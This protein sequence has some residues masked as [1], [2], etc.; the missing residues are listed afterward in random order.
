[1]LPIHV[2]PI[3]IWPI[4]PLPFEADPAIESWLRSIAATAHV[5]FPKEPGLVTGGLQILW[6]KSQARRH[7]IVVVDHP[8]S[9]SIEARQDR[10]SRWRAERCRHKGVSQPRSVFGQRVEI[11][12]FQKRMSR[13]AERVKPMIIR[14]N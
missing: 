7:G 13:A 3:G 10:R 5:P 8:M 14:D 4:C 11:W 2:E 9:V 1:M 6:E 12:R